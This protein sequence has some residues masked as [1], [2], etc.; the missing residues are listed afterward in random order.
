MDG[1]HLQV[2]P[3]GQLVSGGTINLNAT[4]PLAPVFLH[5]I[6][7][8][9]AGEYL[10]IDHKDA[11]ASDF[12]L[13]GQIFNRSGGKVGGAIDLGAASFSVT[14][15]G[16]PGDLN[17]EA[18]F[19]RAFTNSGETVRELIAIDF[20]GTTAT[21]TTLTAVPSTS[22]GAFFVLDDLSVYTGIRTATG[23][24]LTMVFDAFDKGEEPRFQD[25]TSGVVSSAAQL[26]AVGNRILALQNTNSF[27]TGSFAVF[28]PESGSAPVGEGVLFDQAEASSFFLNADGVTE[29]AGV[30]FAV[31]HAD[32][33]GSTGIDSLVVSVCDFEGD[34]L[35]RFDL[36]PDFADTGTPLETILQN[37]SITSITKSDRI[38]LVVSGWV[39]DRNTSLGDLR[40]T[41]ISLA[42]ALD[43]TG[44]ILNDNM[45]GLALGDRLDGAAGDD[46]MLAGGGNDTVFGGLGSDSLS[47]QAGD[48]RLIGGQGS[49]DFTDFF[50]KPGPGGNDTIEGGAGD[51]VVV[52]FNTRITVRAGG[53]DDTVN[54]GKKADHISGD[55]GSD[56]LDGGGGNDTLI[57][58]DDK[59]VI[60]GGLGNDV[61]EGGD[62]NDTISDVD[63]ATGGGL[64]TIHGGAGD[65][66]VFMRKATVKAFGE[67]GNDILQGGEGKDLLDGGKNND[68]LRGLGS[69]DTLDGGE[70]NDF[71]FGGGGRDTLICGFGTDTVKGGS[72]LD[73]FVI[74]NAVDT[75]V[76]IADFNGAGE[77]LD[78]SAFRGLSFAG[79]RI[80]DTPDGCRIV[81]DGTV[82]PVVVLAGLAAA[83]MTVAD[84]LF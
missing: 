50:D 35:G 70:G 66:F 40:A 1:F 42:P 20:K 43:Q 59:D 33:Q 68:T 26:H 84:F 13:L 18:M 75:R 38:D 16:S 10:T 9:E 36:G 53:D 31:L 60:N 48:D 67:A 80:T 21:A 24:D 69:A 51:D 74:R 55:A 56:R 83:E 76:E 78:Y 79:L 6:V 61:I 30:G 4:L 39:I 73:T 34:A 54:G 3:T 32:R 2:S 41:A 46:S 22:G 8:N 17:H 19:L 7:G 45:R 52:Y 72:G 28:G 14:L 27:Q 71:L 82:S 58:G 77:K 12:S 15:V 63:F 81:V 44:T 11:A 29:I 49:D 47:G 5:L 25:L 23:L 37:A 62:G 64:D 65:D 57:G